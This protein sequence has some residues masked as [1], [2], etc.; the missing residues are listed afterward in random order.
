MALLKR[1]TQHNHHM[2][3]KLA[4]R[5]F[6]AKCE[7]KGGITIL[8]IEPSYLFHSQANQLTHL[9]PGVISILCSEGSDGLAQS[10]NH[11]VGEAQRRLPS[12]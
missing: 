9:E 5:Y 2:S 4:F 1:F 7:L 12:S 6:S 10:R 8:T 3:S 11:H